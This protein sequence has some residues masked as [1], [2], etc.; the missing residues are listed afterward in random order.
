MILK[1]PF[2]SILITLFVFNFLPVSKLVYEDVLYKNSNLLNNASVPL[3][4][5]GNLLLVDAT[6]DGVSGVFVLDTGAPGLVLNETYFRDGLPTYGAAGGGISGTQ[7]KRTTRNVE[8]FEFSGLVFEDIKADVI[9]LRH[10]ENAKRVKVLGLIGAKFINDFEIIIDTRKMNMKMIV[11]DRKGEHVEPYKDDNV[12]D[13]EQ[14]AM[15]FNNVVVSYIPIGGKKVCFCL[16][17]GAERNIIDNQSHKN[18]LE[19]VSITG[20]SRIHGASSEKVEVLYGKMNDFNIAGHSFNGMNVIL[21]DLSIMRQ[22]FGIN[23]GGML[24]HDFFNLGVIRI[25]LRKKLMSIALYD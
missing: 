9:N 12:Y 6:V 24:G 15:M 22:S 18:I 3:K 7:I 13:I 11:V 21:M 10:I 19:K 1:I 17:T 8:R 16:D 2:I 25:N 23:V 20:R 5:A 14:K 4:K